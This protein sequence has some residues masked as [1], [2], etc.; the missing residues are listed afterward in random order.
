MKS[1]HS[2][3]ISVPSIV[4]KLGVDGRSGLSPT[5]TETKSAGT[6]RKGIGTV[7]LLLLSGVGTA[8]AAE[9]PRP[10]RDVQVLAPR[11]FGYA[12]GDLI[13]QTVVVTV[14]DDAALDRNS[15]P[16][17]Q[18]RRW[19]E[20]RE[21]KVEETERGGLRRYRIELAYQSFYAPLEVK[22]LAIPAFKLA[23]TRTRGVFEVEVPA[24]HFTTAPIRELSVLRERGLETLRPDQPPDPPDRSGPRRTLVMAL[25]A[26]GASGSCLAYLHGYLP[27]LRRGRHFAA[28]CRA[29]R[30]MGAQPEAA[31]YRAA[32][33][34][35]HRAFNGVY[36]QP[37]FL[38]QL[39]SFFAAW[40]AYAAVKE[41]IEAFFRSSYELF[42]A[43]RPEQPD[44]SVPRLLALCRACRD[45]ERES[46]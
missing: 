21:A 18:V 37:L 5:Y 15:L 31:D 46:R 10:V 26:G 14:G 1:M 27:W 42:F 20:V 7:L 3:R 34:A 43:E 8:N 12:I 41:D 16:Q 11:P 13:R 25:L 39:G 36:G 40:P 44:F 24:W 30:T 2:F 32:Y 33:A 35:V 29:L 9:P 22:T 6:V 38:E 19:L 45:I 17:G 23:F 28:A 4:P